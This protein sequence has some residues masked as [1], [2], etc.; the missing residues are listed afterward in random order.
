MPWA[1]I[2]CG[3]LGVG[4]LKA[5]LAR[6][7]IA[8]DIRHFNLRLAGDLGVETYSLISQLGG[9][10]YRGEIFFSPH[11]FDVPADDFARR[12]IPGYCAGL[13][14]YL[15]ETGGFARY[16]SEGAFRHTCTQLVLDGVPA[17]LEACAESTAWQDYDIVGFSLMFD[18]T[19]AS[20]CLARAIKQRHPH[21]TIVFGGAAC[22][23][24]MGAEIVRS[25]DCVDVV[26]RGEADHTVAGLVRTLR[27]GG[28]L[29]S[30]PGIVFRRGGEVVETNAARR[31]DDMDSLPDPD[32]TDYVAEARKLPSFAPS[33]YFES[34][35]GCWWGQKRLCSFCGL[36]AS[37]VAFR[38]KSPERVLQELLAQE[39][40]HGISSFIA[41]DNIIDLTYFRT[42]LPMVADLNR[43]RSGGRKLTLFY[44]TKSNLKKWQMM[45]L[46]EA[47]VLS[48]QP[49]IESFND[50]VL[51][52]MRKG[53]TGIQQIQYL[54][55]ATEL[56]LA[57]I[58]GILYGSPGETREDY[59]EMRETVG[60]VRHLAPP[61]YLSA[62]A[63]DRFSPY[64]NDPGAYGIRNVRAHESYRRLFPDSQIDHDRLAYRFSFDHDDRADPELQESIRQCL[65]EL[66][67][68]RSGFRPDTLVYVKENTMIRVFDRR[69]SALAVGVLREAQAAI[70]EYC[71]EYHS[72][73]Q[74]CSE[75]S[76][77][78]PSKIHGFLDLLVNRKWMYRDRRDRFISLPIHRPTAS[79]LAEEHKAAEPAHA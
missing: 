77:L 9:G 25:F 21:I 27:S 17:F 66:K 18:Q 4:T 55:W 32:Y 2:R 43:Q 70:F 67:Q 62:V 15:Q 78:D 5:I 41:A 37:G 33:L 10:G 59:V 42:L 57:S 61:V 26:V 34:S 28:N 71:D 64:F 47:G 69:H 44:E 31:V 54:K 22:D 68:W 60:F 7:G 1:D 12:E 38:R 36:N 49:G 45:L 19:L 73:Q 75:F 3:S 14:A 51:E 50:H 23:G 58:Y 30:C 48:L 63:L 72:F 46:R 16:G 56:G 24:E 20:L 53:C 74:I 29:D 79:A 76:H 35:R 39:Q 52:L 65:D 6:E 8:S 13:F 11:F 40:A